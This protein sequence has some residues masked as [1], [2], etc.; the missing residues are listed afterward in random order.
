[1]ATNVGEDLGL[2]AELANGL[3]VC[4]ERDGERTR[5]MGGEVLRTR[6]R[7][8]RCRGARELD[9][10]YTEGIEGLGD[11]DFG[12]GVKERVGELLA[13]WQMAG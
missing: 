7:L 9:V 2:E 8:L 13:L 3:A 5:P 11:G 10:L 1:M 12:L 4:T 6:A